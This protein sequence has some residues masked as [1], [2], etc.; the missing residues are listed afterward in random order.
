MEESERRDRKSTTE[1]R[2]KERKKREEKKRYYSRQV[3][4][5]SIGFGREKARLSILRK[6][7]KVLECA[8]YQDVAETS[9][10]WAREEM[11]ISRRLQTL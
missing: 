11:A 6:E 3:V 7:R 1:K 9:A 4:L 8:G 2:K 10:S 5:I